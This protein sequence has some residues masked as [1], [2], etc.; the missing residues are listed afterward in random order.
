[1][2]CARHKEINF[3]ELDATLSLHPDSADFVIAS[4]QK[5]MVMTGSGVMFEV[6]ET[7]RKLKFHVANEDSLQMSVDGVI[8]CPFKKMG[9][10][11]GELEIAEIGLRFKLPQNGLESIMVSLQ[12]LGCLA[13]IGV[14]FDDADGKGMI[15]ITPAGGC[16][17]Q[18]SVNGTMTTPFKA[19]MTFLEDGVLLLHEADEPNKLRLP[20]DRVNELMVQLQHVAAFTDAGVAFDCVNEG[21]LRFHAACGELQLSCNEEWRPPF[22]CIFIGDDNT[23]RIPE[24]G[25]SIIVP[26]P[27][28]SF[29]KSR[30]MQIVALAGAKVSDEPLHVHTV[31]SSAK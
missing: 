13:K 15:R 25:M 10:S 5:L 6:E 22:K 19:V 12:H 28:Q 30:L 3:P 4:L 11:D 17:L 21:P 14:E 29:V 26:K 20:V 23:I 7:S 9:F 1:M 2:N 18:M 8:Q 27:Q 31:K 24:L 16:Y